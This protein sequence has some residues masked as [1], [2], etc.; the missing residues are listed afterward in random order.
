MTVLPSIL[1]AS[2][3]RAATNLYNVACEIPRSCSVSRGEYSAGRYFVAAKAAGFY[4]HNASQSV[5]DSDLLREI[6]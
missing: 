2:S 5:T 1:R 4:W 3:R 6:G